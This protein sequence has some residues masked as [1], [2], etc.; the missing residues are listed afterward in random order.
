MAGLVRVS[1]HINQQCWKFSS[2]KYLLYFSELPF[3]CKKIPFINPSI[4]I[5]TP[6]VGSYKKNAAFTLI[7]VVITITILG[8]L[9]AIVAPNMST[10][11]VSNRLTT[12]ANEFIADINLARSEAIKQGSN[13]GICASSNSSS[14]TGTWQ[15]GW[16]VYV[17]SNSSVLRAHE[18]LSGNNTLSGPQTDVVF[19]RAGLLTNSAAAGNYTLCNS[20]RG[21]SRTINVQL[22]GRPSLS[23]GSC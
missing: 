6:F 9:L 15:S 22:T 14:C 4:C 23:T 21:M 11:V 7:E 10:F 8:I 17:A 1:M 5:N 2:K 19:N 13:I 20:Q 16:I 3:I 18:S 12:Q